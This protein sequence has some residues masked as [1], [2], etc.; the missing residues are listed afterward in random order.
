M[1]KANEFV[2]KLLADRSAAHVAHWRTGSYSAHVSLGE[3]Y[4]SL[5]DLTDGF[6]EQYQGYHARRMEPRVVAV[7]VDTQEIDDSL[8]LSCE[9]IEMNRYKVCDR[10]DTSLQN[11]IDEILRLYQTT[12]YK[13]RMLK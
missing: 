8:E 10:E 7:S 2:T 1:E 9:W 4:D 5:A 13:L 3:F 12:L 11:T 6:V